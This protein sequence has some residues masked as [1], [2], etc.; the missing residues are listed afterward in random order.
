MKEI[1]FE[2]SKSIMIDIVKDIDAFC[3]KEGID[4]SLAEGS[5][6]G[7]VRH[8]GIIPWDDDIDIL[9]LRDNYERFCNLY[10]SEKYVLQKYDYKLNSWLLCVK[11]T[12]PRTIIRFNDS[13][14]EPFGLWVTVFPID[15]APD[16][17]KK[18]FKMEA[19]IKR[20]MRLFRIR[21][22]AWAKGNFLKNLFFPIFHIA[23]L[24]FSKDYWHNKAEK[25]MIKY[26]HI[27]T[28]RRGSFGFWGANHHPWVCSS[29]AFDE[30]IDTPFDGET[31]RIIKGYDEYLRCQ[32]G[33]Y[34]Q[35]PPEEKRIPK[36][37][38]TPYWKD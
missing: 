25:E 22:H 5:L 1:T 38:Y 28:K 19:N 6:I 20:Y 26:N 7:A 27:K 15:N 4:Y 37:D 21:N 14:E 32:Y 30:Y 2:E 13:S 12:D 17:D 29:N 18:V 9:M 24:P 3:R 36:H 23:L 16:D 10:K 33:D 8:H 34:M 31:F 35:L 11:I